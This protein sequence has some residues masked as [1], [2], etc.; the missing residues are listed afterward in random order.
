MLFISQILTA[1]IFA[2]TAMTAFSYA[3]SYISKGNFKE[4]QLLNY[5]IDKLPNNES[6]ISREHV[7]GWLIHFTIGV[8]FVLIFRLIVDLYAIDLSFQNGIIFG[9]LAGFSGCVVWGL[10]FALH[11][12]PPAIKKALFYFQLIFAHI[13]FGV[14][15]IVVLR[16]LLN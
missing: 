15:M 2:T 14:V 4:P 7:V 10:A 3:F 12:N 9:V 1:S 6:H 13:I 11:P 8:F 5:L 16:S